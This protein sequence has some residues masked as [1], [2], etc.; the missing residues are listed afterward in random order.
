MFDFLVSVLT[1]GAT[2]I[3]GSILGRVLGFVEAWQEEKQTQRDHE[4]TMQMMDKQ[5]ELRSADLENERLIVMEE[6]AGLMKVASFKHDMSAGVSYPFIAAIL[7][8]VRPVLT[9]ALITL[10][11]VVYFYLSNEGQREDIIQSVIWM[12][13]TATM[14]WYGDRA[15]RSRK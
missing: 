2:G 12:A 10:M 11:G 7:R 14:W 13:S 8:L 1:G 9:F 4:R 6:Q 15:M 3:F 5:A